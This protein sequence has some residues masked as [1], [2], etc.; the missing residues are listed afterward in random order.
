MTLP[1][2]RQALA[3]EFEVLRLL[4]RGSTGAV[5]LAREPELRRLV[6]IK[7]PLPELAGDPVVR[8]RFEREARAAAR[9]RHP[10]IAAI[11]RIARLPDDTPY[12]VMEYIDGRPLDDVLRGEGP[13][14]PGQALKVLTRMAEALAEAH[15]HGVIHRDVRPANILCTEDP[16]LAV[17]TDFGIA[18]ILET[19]S[20]VIT[21]LTLPGERLGVAAYRSPEQL[22]GD[23]LTPAT[24]IYGWG[25]VAFEVVTGQ[26]PFIGDTPEVVG[27][28]RLHQPPR[29]VIEVTPD[30]DPLLS[31][32]IDRSLAR[33]PRHRPSARTVLRQLVQ[34][35]EAAEGG[36]AGRG[37]G[38]LP[39]V[40]QLPALAPFLAELQRRRVYNVALGYAA[41]AFLLLQGSELI[42]PA[43]PVPAWAYPAVVAVTLAGFPVALV[44]A[45]MYDLTASGVRRT[46]ASPYLGPPY[47]RW[48]LPAF[49]L[50]LSLLLAI[51]IGFWV[52]GAA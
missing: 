16:E 39:A 18:G 22:L 9:L 32:L 8:A 50:A 3:P 49:G 12:L 43:L 42:L 44:L 41:L 25:L 45:W 33:E 48:I 27:A 6:A 31:E 5:Y 28:L 29:R 20:E 38:M 15:D 35:R 13:F 14:P 47:L 24:D 1:D 11:H 2:V 19:G 40:S 23:T 34:L 17:L 51:L 46:A 36:A 21:R 37:S 4:G 10:G 30:A 26:Q 7:I 52:L